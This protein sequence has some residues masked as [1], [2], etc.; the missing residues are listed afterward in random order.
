MDWKARVFIMTDFVTIVG[1]QSDAGCVVVRVHT[2]C[3]CE[4]TPYTNTGIAIV[5][6]HTS[7]IISVVVFSRSHTHTG[8][9]VICTEMLLRIMFVCVRVYRKLVLVQASGYLLVRIDNTSDCY[10]GN[11]YTCLLI[12]HLLHWVPPR[13]RL[14]NINYSLKPYDFAFVLHVNHILLK[15]MHATSFIWTEKC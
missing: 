10:D 14:Q 3:L 9:R 8:E 7:V 6:V 2:L 15:I 4:W 11:L 13:A 5:L 12:K 1:D